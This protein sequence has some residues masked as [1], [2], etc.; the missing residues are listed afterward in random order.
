MQPVV[1][2]PCAIDRNERRSGP[3]N[4]YRNLDTVLSNTVPGRLTGWF[5]VEEWEVFGVEFIIASILHNILDDGHP[6][7]G[8]IH[9]RFI[10]NSLQSKKV[11]NR[12]TEYRMLLINNVSRGTYSSLRQPYS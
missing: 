9:L 6:T 3:W 10:L 4:R 2:S 11:D 12:I 8:L 7:R 1:L 5:S